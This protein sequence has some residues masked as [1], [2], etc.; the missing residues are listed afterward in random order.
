MNITK[1]A[2]CPDCGGKNVSR[3]GID[4]GSHEDLYECQD[5]GQ[6]ADKS[7]F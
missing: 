3:L 1:Q 4:P 7:D 2:T 6:V 5:C